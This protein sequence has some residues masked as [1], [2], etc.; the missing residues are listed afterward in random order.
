MQLVLV[1][2]P[3]PTPGRTRDALS[4]KDE[5]KVILAA[6]KQAPHSV[7]SNSFQCPGRQLHVLQY[8]AAYLLIDRLYRIV[9]CDEL[10]WPAR[11]PT[12]AVFF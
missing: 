2:V 10:L 4:V 1:K 8:L 12:S 5:R 6:W 11:L 7:P 3:L 9:A